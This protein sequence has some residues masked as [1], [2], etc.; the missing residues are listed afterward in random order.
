MVWN[1]ERRMELRPQHLHTVYMV[2]WKGKAK[3]GND[4]WYQRL[5]TNSESS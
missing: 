3:F 2:K 1:Q 4:V 5:V